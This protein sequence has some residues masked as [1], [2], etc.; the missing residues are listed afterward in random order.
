MY[1]ELFI[2]LKK[3]NSKKENPVPENIIEKILN[4]VIKYPLDDERKKCQ[5]QIEFVIDQTFGV[6]KK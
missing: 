1:D 2:T 6:D 4:L 3:I 5:Q